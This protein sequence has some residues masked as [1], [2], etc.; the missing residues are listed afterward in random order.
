MPSR[1]RKQASE[2]ARKQASEEARKQAS[3]KARKQTSKSKRASKTSSKPASKTG[4]KRQ[5]KAR[6]PTRKVRTIPARLVQLSSPEKSTLRCDGPSEPTHLPIKSPPINSLFIGGGC[7]S[8]DYMR[9]QIPT[10]QY[11]NNSAFYA[12]FGCQW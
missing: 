10:V 4:T 3:E 6:P 11:C 2:K 7:T 1:A 12:G 8:C 9:K 5:R